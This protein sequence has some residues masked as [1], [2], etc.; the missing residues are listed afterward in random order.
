MERCES[1]P[2]PRELPWMWTD[3][4][5]AET[6]SNLSMSGFLAVLQLQVL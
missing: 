4:G 3:P 1:G 2:W 5:I 6:S